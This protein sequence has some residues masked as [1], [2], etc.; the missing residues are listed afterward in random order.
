MRQTLGEFTAADEG[1]KYF[2]VNGNICSPWMLIV[3][4][5][6]G[7]GFGDLIAATAHSYRACILSKGFNPGLRLTHR[8]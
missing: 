3:H 5:V 7:R 1:A 4:D 2:F 6:V 8:C